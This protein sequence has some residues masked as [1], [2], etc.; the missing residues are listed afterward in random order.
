VRGWAD[1]LLCSTVLVAAWVRTPVGAIAR[2]TVAWVRDTPREDVLASFRTTLPERLEAS[3]AS[4]PGLTADT[5]AS[6][7]PAA[8]G[9][10]PAL[11]T[12]AAA[13]LGADTV[14]TLVGLDAQDPEAAL[15]LHTIGATARD[16]AIS[17]ARAAGAVAP[18][19]LDAHARYLSADDARKASEEVSQVLS[20]A[21]ALEL[22]WPVDP[23]ARISSPF[24]ERV[25]PTLKTKRMHEGVD[26]PL[27]VGTP[28]HAAGSGRVARARTDGVNG[29]HVIIDHGH[30][31]RSAYCH[32]SAIHVER[33]ARIDQGTHVMDSGNT[34]R[35]TG[36][37]LHFGLRIAGRPVDPAPFRRKLP[38]PAALPRPDLP[39]LQ[40]DSEAVSPPA[41][42]APDPAG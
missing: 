31:V 29:M 12:A 41:S 27:L 9:W 19:T 39:V 38:T 17:R 13:H 30:R 21:T 18:E 8:G 40:S 42:V 14:T 4:L 34:G 28:V 5:L 33:G 10:T 6:A 7:A 11:R 3:I 24:G 1:L 23:A 20:L 15:E 2:N 16:R 25:H 36:P 26:I 35:S 37:H 32:G 22:A